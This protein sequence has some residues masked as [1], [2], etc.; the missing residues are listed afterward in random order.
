RF[1][2][3]CIINRILDKFINIM[4]FTSP[5]FYYATRNTFFTPWFLIIWV[6][7]IFMVDAY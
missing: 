7:T 5:S 4:I 2:K 3:F 1:F 6:I